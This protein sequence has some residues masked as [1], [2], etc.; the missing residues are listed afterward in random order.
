M[1]V[2]NEPWHGQGSGQLS[3]GGALGISGVANVYYARSQRAVTN[4]GANTRLYDQRI[5]RAAIFA[6]IDQLHRRGKRFGP[7]C[8]LVSQRN[9]EPATCG[10]A[11]RRHWHGALRRTRAKTSAPSRCS[12]RCKTFPSPRIPTA[13]PSGCSLTEFGVAG[14]QVSH[15]ANLRC[16]SHDRADH[17][18]WQPADQHLRLLGRHRWPAR[19]QRKHLRPLRRELQ[20]HLRREP[21]GRTG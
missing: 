5:Q 13:I 6:A 17:G 3:W 12:R 19:R 21:P 16:R 11:H 14:G 9:P 7:L 4:A 20:P 15:A 18:L 10:R 1:D 2:F 8:Q